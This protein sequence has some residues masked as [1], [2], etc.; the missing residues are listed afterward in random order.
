MLK[1]SIIWPFK[2][3]QIW[4][5]SI[6]LIL[7]P[8]QTFG[9]TVGLPSISQGHAQALEVGN[10]DL[11]QEVSQ[12]AETYLPM[13]VMFAIG[14]VGMVI[15]T[16]YEEFSVDTV[17]FAIGEVLYFLSELVSVQNL[18]EVSEMLKLL[19]SDLEVEDFQLSA[20]KQQLESYL[21]VEQLANAKLAF[22]SAAL[23]SF[24]A[25][26]G[27]AAKAYWD[28]RQV[29]TKA[30]TVVSQAM[31]DLNPA[32]CDTA[33]Q[34]ESGLTIAQLK[35]QKETATVGAALYA[36]CV[37]K[38]EQTRG[39]FLHTQQTM[40]RS[41]ELEEQVPTSIGS[42]KEGEQTALLLNANAEVICSVSSDYCPTEV[43]EELAYAAPAEFD[44]SGLLQKLLRMMVPELN[45]KAP[46]KVFGVGS[47]LKGGLRG[48]AESEIIDGAFEKDENG[49]KTSDEAVATIAIAGADRAASMAM[50]RSS[51][52]ALENFAKR[53]LTDKVVK[54]GAEALAKKEFKSKLQ[55]TVMKK[56]AKLAASIIIKGAIGTTGVG[57]AVTGIGLYFDARELYG[58][59]KLL[60]ETEEGRQLIAKSG[61]QEEIDKA[62][63][64]LDLLFGG[65]LPDSPCRYVNQFPRLIAPGIAPPGEELGHYYYRATA[66]RDYNPVRADLIAQ[67]KTIITEKLPSLFLG[68]AYADA[69]GAVGGALGGVVLQQL[70]KH[71]MPIIDQWIYKPLGRMII[72]GAISS[73]AALSIAANLHFQKKIKD[74]ANKVKGL[75]DMT[76]EKKSDP[77]TSFYD[78]S[79]NFI[80]SFFI[81]EAWANESSISSPQNYVMSLNKTLPCLA[82]D[83]I[84]NGQQRACLR[85]SFAINNVVVRP[86]LV[87]GFDRI[88]SSMGQIGDGLSRSRGISPSTGNALRSLVSQ[89]DYLK[90][91]NQNLE[92]NI[93][94]FRS[95]T[96]MAPLNFTSM[97]QRF[98]ASLKDTTESV[99]KK[100]GTSA[101]E[102]FS[103]RKSLPLKE[104]K[105][106]KQA[107]IDDD[108]SHLHDK[109]QNENNTP[110]VARGDNMGMKAYSIYDNDLQKEINSNSYDYDSGLGKEEVGESNLHDGISP[111]SEG[112]LFDQ[113]SNR[114]RQ[115]F[116][117]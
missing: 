98:L 36:A 42:A 71:Y 64:Y 74:A 88:V 9:Q 51:E 55:K 57:L 117:K 18:K 44:Q 8:M 85:P 58:I 14:F 113:I 65:L 41:C 24:L 77:S 69:K 23:A 91:M 110:A 97:R 105:E 108:V 79:E 60:N 114:Y 115:K 28:L 48:K 95:Q 49:Y 37:A 50:D 54:E 43:P 111:R 46:L 89:T 56:F 34:Q 61:Y 73:L 59:L 13:L 62:Q 29:C 7:S 101:K 45:A 84:K 11:P 1:I 93:N 52:K 107:P 63:P 10:A 112:S 16:N 39:A 76:E 47:K 102:F 82:Q 26:T 92:S 6:V 67:A 116:F 3:C 12:F 106:L 81:A 32:R 15:I 38:M 96:G 17:F 72:F 78:S 27:M 31:N 70:M 40:N 4:L 104:L 5:T 87:P 94:S 83:G 66:C 21:D 90:N 25:A 100:L 22:Q 99:L 80:S 53:E 19:P 33:I 109:S 20:L 103:N 68:Q 86:L 35:S 75:I 2:C 30:Q